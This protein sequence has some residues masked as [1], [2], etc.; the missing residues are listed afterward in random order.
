[1]PLWL[2]RNGLILRVSSKRKSYNLAYLS[3]R[4]SCWRSLLHRCWAIPKNDPQ[5][6]QFRMSLDIRCTAD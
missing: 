3:L 5:G 6:E 4:P 2:G 1:M